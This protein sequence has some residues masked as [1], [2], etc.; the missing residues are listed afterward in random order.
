MTAADKMLIPGFRGKTDPGQRAPAKTPPQTR[1]ITVG[2]AVMN[3]TNF[4]RS[5][6]A[7]PLWVICMKKAHPRLTGRPMTMLNEAI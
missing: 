3:W 6:P 4:L 1:K 7:R 5:R 2:M